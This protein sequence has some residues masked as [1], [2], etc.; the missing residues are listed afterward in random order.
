MALTQEIRDGISEILREWGNE[1]VTNARTILEQKGAIASK[2][3]WQSIKNFDIE[4]KNGTI[5]IPFGFQYDEE[6]DVSKYW[7]YVD[8]GVQGIGG[9]RKSAITTGRFK[10]KANGRPIPA[11]PI[12]RWITEKGITPPADFMPNVKL[13][14]RVEGWSYVLA[15]SIK[16]TGIGKTMFWSDTFNEKAYQDLADRIAKKIGGEY[17]IQL[18]GI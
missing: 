2:V 8:E 4:I 15:K 14:K 18:K 9:G 11:K 10:Y 1:R 16:K 13:L 3:L 6:S 7:M 12:Q 5:V 17:T